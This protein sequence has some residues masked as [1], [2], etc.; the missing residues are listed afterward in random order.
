MYSLKKTQTQYA[1]DSERQEFNPPKILK[2]NYIW[3]VYRAY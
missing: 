3:N 2:F 1:T